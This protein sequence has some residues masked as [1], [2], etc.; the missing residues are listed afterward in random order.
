[1]DQSAAAN[2]KPNPNIYWFFITY[3]DEHMQAKCGTGHRPTAV[4]M[5]LEMWK[6]V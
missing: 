1:M 5:G 4:P 2:L 6:L 3:P